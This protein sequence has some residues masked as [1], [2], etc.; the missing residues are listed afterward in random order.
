V[1]D[2]AA[3]RR[4]EVRQL[5]V[6]HRA[7]TRRHSSMTEEEVQEVIARHMRA[8]EYGERN[9]IDW[10]EVLYRSDP[11]RRGK[12]SE[13]LAKRFSATAT[14]EERLFA[15]AERL[16]I[17]TGE[18]RNIEY[19]DH[20]GEDGLDRLYERIGREL[21]GMQPEFW[22]SKPGRPKGRRNK[23]LAETDNSDTLRKRRDRERKR[24][25]RKPD[26]NWS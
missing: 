21:A 26:R 18:F 3:R 2:V 4:G 23:V 9:P 16:G 24:K 20:F 1:S 17:P 25:K 7:M 22:T 15:L 6:L 5:R 8:W 11:R 19:D 14:Q 10:N 12:K 13:S